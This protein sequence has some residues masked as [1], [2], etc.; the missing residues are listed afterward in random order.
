[1]SV[2]IVDLGTNIWKGELQ[3]SSDTSSVSIMFWLRAN[4]G[5]LNNILGTQYIINS[6]TLEP[7]DESGNILGDSEAGIYKYLY[8]LNYYERQFKSFAGIGG[9]NLLIEA[10]SDGGTLRFV[11]RTKMAQLYMQL[12][13]DTEVTLNR[14][15]NKYKF[16]NQTA[17]QVTGDDIFVRPGSDGR[18]G[19]IG[20]QGG[21][22]ERNLF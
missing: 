1:M 5:T 12:R 16:R 7:N 3:E 8:L 11:D 17:V 13:K 9:V 2:K 20:T 14:L 22:F 19:E 21:L 15:V 10:T 18:I 4:I 6:S